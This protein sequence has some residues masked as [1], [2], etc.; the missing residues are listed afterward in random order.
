[1]ITKLLS[2]C[3]IRRKKYSIYIHSCY[4]DFEASKKLIDSIRQTK[5][6]I[7]EVKLFID[8]KEARKR[9]SELMQFKTHFRGIKVFVNI[10]N[11]GDKL[12]HSKAYSVIKVNEDN[13]V[14]SGSLIIGS[15]NLTGN[16]IANQNGNIE[17]FL[18]STS[19]IDVDEFYKQTMKLNFTAIENITAVTLSKKEF[20][21]SVVT[22]GLFIY[23]WKEDL[24]KYLAIKY[25]LTE[26][27]RNNIVS[28]S[29]LSTLGFKVDTASISKRYLTPPEK[30]VDISGWKQYCIETHLGFWM[31]NS[32]FD[33]LSKEN[34]VEFGKYKLETI[35]YL[36]SEHAKEF[37]RIKDEYSKLIE[38]NLIEKLSDSP[39]ILIQTKINE[40]EQ[41]DV[42]LKRIYF[43]YFDFEIP[44]E[45]SSENYSEN[46]KEIYEE[47]VDTIDSRKSLNKT[48]KAFKEAVKT[49]S[50][51]SLLDGKEIMKTGV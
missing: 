45:V 35:N 13:D 12:F 28:Q 32:V 33:E 18:C 48:M 46:I 10:V 8:A 41:N 27:A 14:V 5:I 49:K 1:M 21:E 9:Y 51:L 24:G 7:S 40:L 44:Y 26:A 36:K 16:G 37:D 3:D 23:F 47:M 11:A 42:K 25:E 17:S 19:I 34:D 50:I 29:P 15:G 38:L 22:S 20:R 4:F 6:D 2:G 31:P 30:G 39:E 43:G